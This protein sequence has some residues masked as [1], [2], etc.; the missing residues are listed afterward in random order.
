M[1]S[2]KNL[3]GRREFRKILWS[4]EKVSIE[5]RK[6]GKANLNLKRN[7]LIELKESTN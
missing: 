7:T 5:K 4:F 3:C 6:G 2:E 1:K